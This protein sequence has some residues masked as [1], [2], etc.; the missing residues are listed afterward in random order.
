M[1][2]SIRWIVALFSILA[3]C[4][5]AVAAEDWLT[6]RGP[7]GTGQSTATALPLTW[8][9]TENIKWKV[10]LDGPG[11][12]S[13]IVVGQ[14][15]FITHAPANTALRGIHCYDRTSG[16]LLWKHQ[17]EFSEPER[18]HKT[19]P[20]CAA[21]PVSDGERIVAWYGTPGLFCYDQGGKILWQKSLGPLDNDW[22]FG[23]SPAIVGDLAILNFGPGV[24]AFVIALDKHTGNEV[25]R[26][27]FPAQKS[28]KWDEFRG[29]WSTPVVFREPGRSV[30]LLSLP[31]ALWAVDPATGADR[32]HCEGL[33]ALS[34]T[35]P[36][37]A[38]DTVIA[39]SGY[40]GPALAVKSGGNGDVTATHR[41][42]H[43]ETPKPPQRVGS[44]VVVGN[45][46]Y[47]LNEPGVAWCLDAHTGEKKWEE[48]LGRAKS[49]C[50][51]VHAAGHLYISN[52]AGATYVLEPNP[53]A[54]KILA[55][56][57]LDEQ[58]ESSPAF[59]DGQIFLRTFENLYCISKSP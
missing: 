1:N 6:W 57:E 41:L 3:L 22:G 58:I 29:S 51:M 55:E 21:S 14:K 4:P 40:G 31:A 7:E 56:N 45:H 33:G 25:W 18:T 16:Q 35:S 54:L 15:V 19:N 24:N 12:S 26:R 36:L 20:F 59:S 13:P 43:H 34:Y 8:S 23:S 44:G 48:R 28:A 9:K 49:W 5:N 37:V 42:W 50:S 47:I 38:S 27:E 53:Q 32:W 11:N 10:P 39:M 30:L 17:I 52:K 46:V 2:L